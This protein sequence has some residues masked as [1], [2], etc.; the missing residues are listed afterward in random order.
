VREQVGGNGGGAPLAQNS[1]GEE[2]RHVKLAGGEGQWSL[3][4]AQ[5]P[6]ALGCILKALQGAHTEGRDAHKVRY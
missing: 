3:E 4:L 5:H 1:R 2:G 6:V